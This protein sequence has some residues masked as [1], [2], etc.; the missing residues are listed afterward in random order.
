[1][2]PV[3]CRM[4]H[5]GRPRYIATIPSNSA[6]NVQKTKEH[7]LPWALSID[8]VRDAVT[9]VHSMT[10]IK[11]LLLTIDMDRLLILSYAYSSIVPNLPDHLNILMLNRYIAITHIV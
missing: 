5:P 3:A 9:P 2:M 1:M 6:E 4:S 7:R 11:P 10:F 8:P